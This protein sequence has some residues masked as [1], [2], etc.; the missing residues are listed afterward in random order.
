M[1]AAGSGAYTIHAMS[2]TGTIAIIGGGFS[3]AALAL[4]L[5]RDAAAEPEARG[6]VVLIERRPSV[7]AG[8]AYS[9]PE[10]LHLLNVPAGR[11]S[12]WASGDDDGFVRYARD[13]DPSVSGGTFVARG[14]YGA[15]VESELRRLTDEAVHVTFERIDGEAVDL[16]VGAE[17]SPGEVILADRRIVRAHAIV[18]ATGYGPPGTPAGVAAEVLRSPR[19]VADPWAPGALDAVPAG[20]AILLLGTGLTMFDV[21]ATL[22]ARGAGRAAPVLA[23]SRRGLLPQPHRSPSQPPSL[24]F[25]PPGLTDGPATPLAYLRAVRRHAA[26][27][28]LRGV[29]WRDVLNSLRPLTPGLWTRLDDDQRARFCRHVRP[30]WDT[31]RHRSAPATDDAVRAMLSAGRLQVRAARLRALRH[32]DDAMSVTLCPRGRAADEVHSFGRVINCTGPTSDPVLAPDRLTHSLRAHG[33]L[34]RSPD[35]L[36]I[37]VAP[38]LSLLNGDG[39]A[40]PGVWVLGPALK[41]MYWEATAVPELRVHAA[42][43]ASL[44]V[45]RVLRAA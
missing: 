7:G 14:V 16:R 18:L 36:G 31:H 40:V 34:D 45:G 44:L 29:D 27:L 39:R 38:D 8:V 20:E 41:A 30:Y 4:H 32:A 42:A 6:R 3:G 25:V 10:P 37:R 5:L 35:G 2:D 26:A 11:M 43:L 28:A 13:I 24:E 33:L 22:D 1:D 12:V 23:V 17:G 19:Y 21:A 9:T 15:Y